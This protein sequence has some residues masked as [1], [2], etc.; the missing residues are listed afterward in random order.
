MTE[1]PGNDVRKLWPV[2]LAPEA[3]TWVT[4]NVTE[5]SVPKTEVS[6]H[7]AAGD[8]DK[9]ALPKEDVDA[10]VL[11]KGNTIRYLPE[12]PPITDVQGSMH[13]DG[14]SMN[15]K[16]DSAHFLKQTKLS[17][18]T[19]E[20]ADLNA[21][22]PY[23][24]VAFDINTH[25]KDA[26]HF[27]GLPR[28]QH[29]KSLNL[30]EE[31]IEGTMT[32]HGT[33]GFSFELDKNG[34]DDISYD[35][36][37]NV[38]GITQSGFMRKFD[39]SDAVGSAHVDNHVLE[40]KGTG[41]VN[42]A[43]LSA[44]D[45]KYWFTSDHPDK[46]FNTF[47]D[48]TATAPVE[49][50][51]RFGYPAFAFLKGTLGMKASIKEGDNT[52]VSQATIDLNHAIVD[53]PL[54]EWKKPDKEA[55]TLELS[56]DKTQEAARIPAFHL[57]GK[58][59]DVHGKAEIAKDLS[60]IRTVSIDSL[61]YF[62]ST[63]D[64]LDYEKNDNGF[65]IDMHGNTFDLRPWVDAPGENTFSFEHFPAVVLNIDVDQLVLGK[66]RTLRSVK[67]GADCDIKICSQADIE[68]M[69]VDNKP[70]QFRILHNPKDI[71]Q[72]SIHAQ[73]GGAFMKAAG[74]LEGM[75]GGDLSIT[76]AYDDT[77]SHSVLT[78]AADST[79][80]TIKDAPVLAKMVSLAS[81]TGIVDNLQGKGISFTKL[82]FPFTM[83]NDVITIVD[84]KTHG[85]AIGLT[86]EGTITFPK[87]MLDL[88]GTL[89]PSY[90]L[91]NV[92]GHVPLVGKI[93][94]GGEG[95]GVFAARY[96]ITGLDT[97]PDVSVN[98]LSI[99]TPGFLRNVFDVFDTPEKKP[100]DS[101]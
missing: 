45:I 80:F 25:A 36:T 27:L 48:V 97:K 1:I 71:R 16:I 18:G 29:S 38:K 51:P 79:A 52:E 72:L 78:A 22:N 44:A 32:G 9:P 7:I 85:D 3:R 89:I 10:T 24:K 30:N 101:Q 15:A 93:L 70:F 88:K 75:E 23:I 95:Q 4:S 50:L 19:V 65:K 66:D 76:G 20:I 96:S 69:T 99:L 61:S 49:S 90:S 54:F 2:K 63:L 64:H 13:I 33:V 28:L 31:T 98:P 100:D 39:I 41:N 14:V 77:G 94:T 86:M 21:D 26:V 34:N 59:V 87:R 6:I 92:L 5:G 56:G 43:E 47:I 46:R 37:G 83:S 67:G 8:I 35:V 42:G 82:R 60:D 58:N 84:G 57:T 74:V 12:H 91:N 11:L 55:A 53:W 40:F 81:L 73:S 17:A 68:G 62:G